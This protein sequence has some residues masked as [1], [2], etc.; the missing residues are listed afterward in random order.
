MATE[1]ISID[2]D[3]THDNNTEKDDIINADDYPT[4][5]NNEEEE[6]DDLAAYKSDEWFM[7]LRNVRHG[8]MVEGLKGYY[9]SSTLKGSA[10][11]FLSL[12]KY[13]KHCNSSSGNNVRHSNRKGGGSEAAG[14]VVV[15]EVIVLDDSSNDMPVETHYHA[16]LSDTESSNDLIIE[17]NV[18]IPNSNVDVTKASGSQ[19]LN[20]VDSGDAT[21][22]CSTAKDKLLSIAG[23]KEVEDKSG[24]DEGMLFESTSSGGLVGKENT[25][26]HDS[27]GKDGY[28]NKNILESSEM[29]QDLGKSSDKVIDLD[30]QDRTSTDLKAL[31]VNNE[32]VVDKVTIADNQNG[33]CEGQV[34]VSNVKHSEKLKRKEIGLSDPGVSCKED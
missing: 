19:A 1:G 5:K 16:D 17:A 6:E 27:S 34:L 8:R 13:T 22:S 29:D 20:I 32:I 4:G 28:S 14:A 7:D 3:D 25:L 9:S 2:D 10:G 26:I 12:S 23:K 11:S 30:S 21:A 15:E 18:D 33:N 31:D 24:A